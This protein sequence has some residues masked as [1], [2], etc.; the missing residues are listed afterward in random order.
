MLTI[1]LFNFVTGYVET[2]DI[3][4]KVD[5]QIVE[6]YGKEYLWEVRLK[7]LGRTDKDAAKIIVEECG[8]PITSEEFIRQSKKIQVDLLRNA[9]F[10]PGIDELHV[11]YFDW[12]QI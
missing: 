6:K 7:V 4:Y 12:N 2:E 9:V 3:Y 10:C 5:K 8:L 11:L 1:F